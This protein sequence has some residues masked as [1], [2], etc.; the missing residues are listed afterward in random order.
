MVK[1]AQAVTAARA[2]HTAAESPTPTPTPTSAHLSAGRADQKRR[3]RAAIVDAARNLIRAGADVSMPDVAR[4]A[5]VSEAT[6][7]RYFPDLASLLAEAMAGLWPEPAETL[8][9][10]AGSG[11][12]VERV[13]FAAEHLLRQ[14]LRYQCAVRTMIA[15]TITRPAAAATRPGLRF[16]LIEYAL[17]PLAD[18][19]ARTSPE[20]LTRLQRDLAV[21]VSAEALFTLT[22]LCGLNPDAAVASTVRAATTLTE[23]ALAEVA[24]TEAALHDAE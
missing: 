18:T 11:D 21:V 13:A 7:Y 6:A 17:T 23:A 1:A 16:G 19:L 14:V 4:A 10:V 2:Q 24:L 15:A 20:R 5:P 8:R 22:D 3:T 12:A 9:P